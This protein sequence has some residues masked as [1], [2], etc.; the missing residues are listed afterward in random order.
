MAATGSA[1]QGRASAHNLSLDDGEELAA[2][3]DR[4]TGGDEGAEQAL[5]KR[6][7]RGVRLLVR[8]H[9]R[10]NDPIAEDVA[11]EVLCTLVERVRAGAIDEPRALPGYLR[12]MIVH[13]V[14]AEYRDRRVRE[15]RH[16]RFAQEQESLVEADGVER[17]ERERR[18][19]A[20][21][22][23]LAELPVARDRELLRRFYLL[24]QGKDEVCAALAI[25]AAHFRR[26]LHRARKRFGELLHGTELDGQG[27]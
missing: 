25:D 16:R 13:A 14:S 1:P 17:L 12:T 27:G 9:C 22:A 11:Q 26:V 3:I 23:L 4:V 19:Q 24:D 10:P 8:R 20:L 18:R 15:E 21:E 5:L 6:F 7:D 2:L